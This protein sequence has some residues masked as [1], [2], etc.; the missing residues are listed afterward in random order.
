M[1][2]RYVLFVLIALSVWLMW[3]RQFEQA[4]IARLKKAKVAAKAKDSDKR[5]PAEKAP[6]TKGEKGAEIGPEA[7]EKRPAVVEPPLRSDIVLGEAPPAEEDAR[8]RFPTVRP[9]YQPRSGGPPTRPE[10][11]S[12]GRGKTENELHR[13]GRWRQTAGGRG[14]DRSIGTLTRKRSRLFRVD[15]HSR[16]QTERF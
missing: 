3:I 2:R 7:A 5:A 16:L 1:E 9:A 10:R 6:S 11:L 13:R 15:R 14:N 4:E 8:N 12:Q